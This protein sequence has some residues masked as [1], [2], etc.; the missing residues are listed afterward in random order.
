M[1]LTS[2]LDVHQ[3]AFGTLHPTAHLSLSPIEN[4]L[5]HKL[6]QVFA[7][8]KIYCFELHLLVCTGSQQV[9]LVKPWSTRKVL[10]FTRGQTKRL[11]SEEREPT[12][13]AMAASKSFWLYSSTSMMASSVL[14]GWG[15]PGARPS[16]SGGL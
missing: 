13:L 9:E 15:K 12:T 2:F 16:S 10:V 5:W 14:A 3:A 11:V 6:Q 4:L 7:N 8:G 1:K